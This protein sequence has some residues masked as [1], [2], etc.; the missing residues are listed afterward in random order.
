VTHPHKDSVWTAWRTWVALTGVTIAVHVVGLFN[1]YFLAFNA[2]TSFSLT[3]QFWLEL[4]AYLLS[5]P[6]RPTIC[7][8]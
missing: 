3:S 5:L 7:H 8:R 6:G 4:P 2:D 1:R